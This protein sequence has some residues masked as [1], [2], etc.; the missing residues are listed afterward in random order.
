MRSPADVDRPVGAAPVAARSTTLERA[1]RLASFVLLGLCAWALRAGREPAGRR[2][3][4]GAEL[5]SV[6]AAWTR[7]PDAESLHVGLIAAPAAVER[8]WLGAL[9][10]AGA[11]VTWSG[12]PPATAMEVLPVADPSGGFV[13]LAAAS[14]GSVVLAD[15]LGVIDSTRA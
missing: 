9:S 6:L 4:P 11:V 15:S 2:V 14:P 13:V 10:A 12:A 8:D 5:P 3:A 1:L 7:V